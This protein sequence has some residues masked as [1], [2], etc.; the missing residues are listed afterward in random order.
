LPD[1]KLP[2]VYRV[3]A[4]RRMAERE[5][6]EEDVAQVVHF[7]REIESYPEDKPYASRLMLGWA[8]GRPIH[9]V[10]A[11]A[12][13]EIIVITVYEPD[14]ALWDPGFEKRKP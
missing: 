6:R 12:E 8:S 5:I 1:T 11:T 2:L 13:H 3:H 10:A 4:V 9:V 7:G 14:P